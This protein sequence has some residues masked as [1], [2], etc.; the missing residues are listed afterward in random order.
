MQKRFSFHQFRCDECGKMYKYQTSLTLHKKSHANV[1]RFICDLCGKSFVRAHG[2]QSH[3][4][5]HSTLTPFTCDYNAC[6]KQFK[7]A[8]ML[9]NHHKRHL[10]VKTFVC[11][12]ADCGKEFITSSELVTHVR[13]HTGSKVELITLMVHHP[14][15]ILNKFLQLQ[16]FSCSMCDKSY[17]TKSHLNV[18]HRS[19][20]GVR[21]YSCDICPLTFAHNKVNATCNSFNEIRMKKMKRSKFQVLKHHRLVHLGQLVSVDFFFGFYQLSHT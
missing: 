8:I 9:R 20:S 19:H 10:G 13:S 11:S 3:L 6:G 12:L 5:S 7:N 18:H 1:R 2:L 15:S 17:K 16:P 14:F 4:L 21:P